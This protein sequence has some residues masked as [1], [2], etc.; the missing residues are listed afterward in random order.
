MRAGG[1][2]S[3]CNSLV[4]AWMTR[5]ERLSRVVL[6]ATFLLVVAGGGILWAC[7]VNVRE[8]LEKWAQVEKR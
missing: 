8:V 3:V 6:A 1:N 2:H 5:G 4:I 7:H